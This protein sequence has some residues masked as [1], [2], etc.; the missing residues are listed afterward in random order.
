MNL[1]TIELRNS[2]GVTS[3]VFVKQESFVL[4][5]IILNIAGLAINF[6]SLLIQLL[7]ALSPY[8]PVYGKVTKIFGVSV[9]LGL[10]AGPYLGAKRAMRLLLY[11]KLFGGC[12]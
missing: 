7:T 5:H 11:F 8:L 1:Y 9:S 3:L 12:S 10:L 4:C 2:L 6:R